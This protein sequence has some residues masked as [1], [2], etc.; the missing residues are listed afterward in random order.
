MG[1]FSKIKNM[2]GFGDDNAPP[3][4][5]AKQYQGPGFYSGLDRSGQLRDEFSVQRDPDSEW[6]QSMVEGQATSPY[7]SRTQL[8]DQAMQDY[9][10]AAGARLGQMIQGM[11][12]QGTR[13]GD[14]NQL[15]QLQQRR[16]PFAQ[17][18]I[19]QDFNRASTGD[20]LRHALGQEQA[21]N[22]APGMQLQ[23]TWA[24]SFNRG[25]FL[26]ELQAENNYRS[27]DYNRQLQHTAAI[28]QAN[29]MGRS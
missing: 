2:F 24:D 3:V 27:N 15:K 21:V 26:K 23:G 8:R 19:Q 1:L 16:N 14:V 7:Q 17:R 4:Y 11:Q 13:G 28:E 22:A 6:A 9:E 20:S 29:A 10:S 25:N 5:Q 12:I 18:E